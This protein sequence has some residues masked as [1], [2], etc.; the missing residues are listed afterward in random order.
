MKN[1]SRQEIFAAILQASGSGNT[2]TRIMYGSYLS[3]SQLKYCLSILQKNNL[4]E[5][6]GKIYKITRKGKKYV[7]KYQELDRMILLEL[8]K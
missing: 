4:I 2:I 7:Q 1:R 5:R 3:Y 8:E 6:N